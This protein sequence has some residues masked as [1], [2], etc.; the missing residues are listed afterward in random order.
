MI[1]L[2]VAGTFL[3]L[4]TYWFHRRLVRAPG[5]T[6]RAALAA[7][8]VLVALLAAASIASVTGTVLDPAWARPLGFLGYSWFAAGL[9]L[10]IGLL[11]IGA[12]CLG[13]RLVRRFRRGKSPSEEAGASHRP[14]RRALRIATATLVAATVATIGYGSLI[15]AANPRLVHSTI[16]LPGLPDE[17]DGIRVAL[18]TDLHVGPARG[19]GFV[20]GVVDQVN[21]QRPDLIVLGGDLADGTVELVGDD[22]A[23]LSEL[24]APLG[25][26][27]V[28]GNHEYYSD[29]ASSWLDHWETL[30]VKTLRNENVLVTH[31]GE[32]IALAGV[33][34]Y[35]APA[36]DA[37]DL[38]RAIEGLAPET[39]VLLAAHQPKHVLEAQDLGVD[40]QLS[41]HTHGG[42]MWP[43]G[44]IVAAANPTVTGL[45][46][47]GDT[48]IYTSLG[49]GA[50]GPPVRVATPPEVS[51][52]ELV[53]QK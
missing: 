7:D 53:T 12:F 21:E 3:A 36:P 25:I 13:A 38:P 19:A 45:D 30:G 26:Y 31:N 23:P 39:F 6:G 27:G 16:A 4:I 46:H 28:S 49:A 11:V 18:I 20:R 29:D 5:L 10:I 48:A 37:A 34:D 47:F 17:F 50:W 52:L 9:Y 43:L 24:R 32:Q 40:L 22:L 41:G 8:I 42:Q 14:P 15:E 1:R 2:L 33:H 44:Y 51:I 35:T